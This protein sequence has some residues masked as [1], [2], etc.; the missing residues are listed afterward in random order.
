MYEI[1]VY[2]LMFLNT[3]KSLQ[4]V[5]GTITGGNCHV[6]VRFHF[7]FAMNTDCIQ[8]Y[9]NFTMNVKPLFNFFQKFEN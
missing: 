8:W 6:I 2:K 9:A 7:F 5:K 3:E 4:G 1:S